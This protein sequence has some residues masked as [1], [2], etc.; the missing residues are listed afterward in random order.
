MGIESVSTLNKNPMI[1]FV[2]ALHKTFFF[3]NSKKPMK[4]IV[5]RTIIFCSTPQKKSIF[6]SFGVNQ[7]YPKCVFEKKIT[8]LVHSSNIHKSNILQT[9]IWMAQDNYPKKGKIPNIE[10]KNISVKL[11]FVLLGIWGEGIWSL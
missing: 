6:M 1:H 5:V 2:Q 8:F 4:N 11:Y 9:P 7:F 10:N 3:G